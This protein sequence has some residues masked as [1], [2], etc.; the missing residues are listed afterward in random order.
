M[1]SNMKFL[2]GGDGKDHDKNDHDVNNHNDNAGF[3]SCSL[4][5]PIICIIIQSLYNYY[6]IEITIMHRNEMQS[7]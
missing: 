3:S 5:F 4:S 2:V 7:G 6:G 1:P